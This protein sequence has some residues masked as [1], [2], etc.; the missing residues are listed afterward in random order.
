[1]ASGHVTCL[2]PRPP[3]PTSYV[4]ARQGTRNAESLHIL[5]LFSLSCFPF[6]QVL[7]RQDIRFRSISHKRHFHPTKSSEMPLVVPGIIPQGGDKSK[8]EEWT[9]KL[10]GKKLGE[11]SDATVCRFLSY[12]QNFF[13]DILMLILLDIRESRTAQGDSCHS[14]RPNGDERFQPREASSTRWHWKRMNKLLTSHGKTQ[15]LSRRGWNRF[16]R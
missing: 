12:T 14:A 4:I 10:V 5:R 16:S 15:R 2:L 3:H 13:E 7:S 9:N 8:T 11:G 6:S 1:M